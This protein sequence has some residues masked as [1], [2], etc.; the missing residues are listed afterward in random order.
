M[1]ASH[2]VNKILRLGAKSLRERV[3][4]KGEGEMKTSSKQFLVK[5]MT[6]DVLKNRGR[7]LGLSFHHLNNTGIK[8]SLFWEMIILHKW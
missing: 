7:N 1:R 6:K 3:K 5:K 2:R 8:I 4:E